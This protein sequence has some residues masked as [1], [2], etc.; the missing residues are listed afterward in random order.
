[1]APKALLEAIEPLGERAEVLLLR[2]PSFAAM[3]AAIREAEQAGQPYS[4]VHFDGHG[5]FDAHRGL[6]ALCFESD[7]AGE[8]EKLEGRKTQLVYADEILAELR[9]F[10]IPFF[11]LD[12]CQSAVAEKD[13][14]A[15]VAATLLETGAASV[16]AMSYSVLVSTAEVFAK[17]FYA[18]LAG[19]SRIGS[20]MLAGQRALHEDAVRGELPQGEKLRL[21]DWFVPVLYQEQKDPRLVKEIPGAQSRQIM[22][23]QRAARAGEVPDKPYGGHHFVGRKRELLYLERLLLLEPYAVLQGPGGAGKTTLAAE[24]ARWMLRTGR[25][26]RLAFLSFEGVRDVRTA[27]LVLGRQVLGAD[28]AQRMVAAEEKAMQELERRLA[29]YSTLILLDNMESIQPTPDGQTLP[30]V[31]DFGA[32]AD[33]FSRLLKSSPA[34][35]LLFTTREAL[36]A[37]FDRGRNTRRIGALA[38]SDALRLIAELMKN[39]G[40]PV[41]SLNPED[42]EAQFGALARTAGYHARA[43]TLLTKSLAQ[44]G[45]ALPELNA[46]L[47]QLMAELERRH[48]GERENS[49][50]ASLELS[51]RRLPPALRPV[52][53]ALAVYHGG[54]DVATWAMVAEC[55]PQTAAQAG[56]ALVQVGLAEIVLTEFPY[57]FQ[58]DPALPAWLAAQTPPEPLAERRQRWVETM[59]A[60]SG[61]LYEQK[62]QNSTLAHDL[63]RLSEANLVAMLARLEEVEEPERVVEVA[64]NVESIFSKLSRPAVL[65]F[66]QKIREAAAARLELGGGWS[67]A[68]FISKSAAVD[69]LLEQGNLPAAFQLAQGVLEQCERAGGSAYPGAEYDGAMAYFRLG[70]VLQMAGQAEKALMYLESARQ[71]FLALSEA[72]DTDAARMASGCLTEMGDCFADS[73][74]YEAAAARYQEA[75]KLDEKRGDPRQVAVAKGQLAT[76]RMLQ[77]NY[78][79]ALRLYGEAKAFFERNREAEAIATAW[80]QIGVVHERAQNY[81]AAE[82]AY[83]ESLEIEI[84]EKNMAGEASSLGQLGNLY[85]AM[86]RLEDALRMYERAAGIY[87]QLKDARYEGFVRNNLAN[88]LLK[89]RRPAEARTELQRAIECDAQFGHAARPWTTWAILSN[90]ETSEGN[91]A[92]APTARQKAMSAYAAY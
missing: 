87:A 61:F 26:Q 36:P 32:F 69:R 75:M 82:R 2:K 45:A 48:P 59:V 73:G 34:T 53:D 12:A 7:E 50:F 72:G 8:Q 38:P 37:P 39:E 42:L 44:R 51:L 76:V 24:L 31:E 3:C 60:L 16:A 33:F 13:P 86:G 41:P 58:I 19:G 15:S 43:L 83:Q 25:F 29:E 56:I 47:S 30:G 77:K 85:N 35:R 28:F 46:D 71:R 23:A 92:A 84:R 91:S 66:A 68:Q 27:L 1:M 78:P 52:V 54:A 80:H 20:A 18:A 49:L 17:A 10:R 40:I 62:F 64:D 90:L 11:F 5:V 22:D 79:E 81:P 9:G 74:Q 67:H 88:T 89:L 70:R 14:T 55:E 65:Q 4:V 6:G 57:F 63:A 21:H